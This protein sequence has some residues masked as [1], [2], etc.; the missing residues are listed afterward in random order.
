MVDTQLSGSLIQYLDDLCQRR[1]S[2]C[3]LGACVTEPESLPKRCELT[4]VSAPVEGAKTT[5]DVRCQQCTL[6]I[7]LQSIDRNVPGTPSQREWLNRP[8]RELGD[9]T[10]RECLD[11]GDYDAVINVLW[12]LDTSEWTAG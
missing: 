12:L 3:P 2:E 9:R 6:L 4:I 8:L 11:A 1:A 10:P 5:R 7:T